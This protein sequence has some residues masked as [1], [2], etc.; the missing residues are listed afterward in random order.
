V[1]Q[2]FEFIKVCT[3]IQRLCLKSQ[4][5]LYFVNKICLPCC[6]V[7]FFGN[8]ESLGRLC[9]YTLVETSLH[10]NLFLVLILWI[11]TSYESFCIYIGAKSRN[12]FDYND[13]GQ[14]RKSSSFP[15]EK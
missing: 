11:T 3:G 2:R 9:V 10:Q 1:L 4:L 5:F 14:I 13:A 7:V 6:C 12:T 15:L 8:I